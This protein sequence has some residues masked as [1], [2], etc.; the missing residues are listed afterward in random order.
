MKPPGH[1]VTWTHRHPDAKWGEPCKNTQGRGKATWTLQYLDTTEQ[2]GQM[3]GKPTGKAQGSQLR[4]AN[5]PALLARTKLTG[6]GWAALGTWGWGGL[7]L[8]HGTAPLDNSGTRFRGPRAGWGLSSL[9]VY[10][11]IWFGLG[12]GGVGWQELV[13]HKS[14]NKG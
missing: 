4:P 6:L 8:A 12:G 14:R 7:H 10:W 13:L 1:K 2:P 3:R 11:Y 9:G 5:K